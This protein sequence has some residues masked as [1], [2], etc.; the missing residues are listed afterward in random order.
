MI[1][2]EFVKF[3]LFKIIL[4]KFGDFFHLKSILYNFCNLLSNLDN[5]SICNQIWLIFAICNHHLKFLKL[6]LLFIQILFLKNIFLRFLFMVHRYPSGWSIIIRPMEL[7][8]RAG[9]TPLISLHVIIPTKDLLIMCDAGAGKESAASIRTDRG[10]SLG[11]P[12]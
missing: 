7:I 5:F 3:Y 9:S 6:K 8:E 12:S 11:S 1:Y 2:F 10:F 4:I